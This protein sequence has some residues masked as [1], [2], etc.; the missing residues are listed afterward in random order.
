MP[1]TD[2]NN[3]HIYGNGKVAGLKNI[4]GESA[5]YLINEE[6]KEELR[7]EVTFYIPKGKNEFE[8]I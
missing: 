2:D 1:I 8:I 5:L 6:T 4:K 3:V 7:L